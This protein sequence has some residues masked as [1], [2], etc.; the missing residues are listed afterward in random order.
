MSCVSVLP[1][2][3]KG[4]SG[5]QL[6]EDFRGQ[7]FILRLYCCQLKL[8]VEMVMFCTVYKNVSVER[9]QTESSVSELCNSKTLTLRLRPREER[10]GNG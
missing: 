3:V 7:G 10:R 9:V 1:R 2:T 4:S 5:E 8:V 6:K